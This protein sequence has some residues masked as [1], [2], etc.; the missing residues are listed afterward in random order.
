MSDY[1]LI[2]ELL[3]YLR[4]FEADGKSN[5]LVDFSDYLNKELHVNTP[6]KTTLPDFSLPENHLPEKFEE[7]EFSTLLNGLYRFARHY[8]K[9]A[10]VST[11]IKTLEEFGFL[12]SLIKTPGLL[13][14]ELIKLQLLEISSG[15]E[16]LRRLIQ[17]AY[18]E[19]IAD[20]NDRRSKRLFLTQKG[21]DT[22]IEAFAEMYKAA[23]IVRGNL[24]NDE[25]ANTTLAMEKL[26]AFHWHIHHSDKS[27]DINSLMEKY[28]NS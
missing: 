28:I 15:T 26:T 12:A 7:V 21:R 10:L 9:K 14:S 6:V 4:R 1:Y 5:S 23:K 8:V 19:E 27:T 25:L 2:Q 18:I 3:P 22:I 16:V 24:T 11:D 17:S 13:K 20:L